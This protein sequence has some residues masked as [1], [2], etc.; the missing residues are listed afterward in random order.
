MNAKRTLIVAT[1]VILLGQMSLRASEKATVATARKDLIEQICSM[2]SGVPFE[3][4]SSD[5]SNE[6]T[7][8]FKIAEN[9][10]FSLIKV[11]GRNE[12]LVH[13][14]TLK[15]ENNP[16]QATSILVGSKYCIPVSY[17]IKF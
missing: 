3:L 12:S 5:V 14:V 7:I 6:L 17:D 8:K 11:E 16:I 15:M 13:Y 4:L 9:G 2:V 10:K 1:L